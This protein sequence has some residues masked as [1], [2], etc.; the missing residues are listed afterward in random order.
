MDSEPLKILLL[1]SAYR[2]GDIYHIDNNPETRIL[3]QEMDRTIEQ[4]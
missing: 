4:N 1:M 3:L 2:K